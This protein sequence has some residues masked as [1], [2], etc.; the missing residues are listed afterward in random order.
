MTD[1]SPARIGL[2]FDY[3]GEDGTYDE[4]DLWSS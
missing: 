4:N 3:I 2:L 1:V